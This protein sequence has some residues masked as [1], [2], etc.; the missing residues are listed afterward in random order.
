MWSPWKWLTRIGVDVLRIDA[1][2]VM[3]LTEVADGRRAIVAEAG[4]DQHQILAG[5]HDQDVELVDDVVGRQERVA[6]RL[7]DSG[8]VL[9]TAMLAGVAL[10]TTP[11]SAPSL[12]TRR[13]CSDRSS[14]PACRPSARRRAIALQ[15]AAAAI[16]AAPASML[17]RVSGSCA[18][19]LSDRARRRM[20]GG[21]YR[22]RRLRAGRCGRFDTE[23]ATPWLARSRSLDCAITKDRHRRRPSG[24]ADAAATQI[25]IPR[26]HGLAIA[27][28]RSSRYRRAP[29]T[30]SGSPAPSSSR[31]RACR[32]P[33]AASL[34]PATGS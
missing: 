12:R 25:E 3:L 33:C 14:A 8:S 1:G 28:R 4:V 24:S 9:F 13:S 19:P 18:P 26:H 27:V 30:D 2:A 23:A 7:L 22:I 21:K 15:R 20:L 29:G 34:P 17:R 10:R 5:V 31:R 11:R 16:A 6:E 32:R